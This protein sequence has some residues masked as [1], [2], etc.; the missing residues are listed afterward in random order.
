M[1]LI[2]AAFY[3]RP[4]LVRLG[5][6]KSNEYR[7]LLGGRLFEPDE[8]NPMIALRGASRYIDPRFR[9][10]SE[11]ECEALRFVR[12]Q[13]G[14][15]NLQLMIPFC[16]SPEEGQEVVRLLDGFG[17]SPE[18]GVPLFLMVELPSNVLDAQRFIEAMNLS[19]GS[20]GSNDLVQTV[21]AVSRDDLEHYAH[22]VDARSPAVK[23]MIR[24]AVD[25]FNRNGLEIGICG[26]APSD[27]PED[28]PA[29]LVSCGITSISVTPDTLIR[30][31]MAVAQAEAGR[32][33]PPPGRPA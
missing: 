23:S 6:L 10:A 21:Y 27:H 11:M 14:L 29:F 7:D 3:P 25:E 9:P 22:P 24:M 8:E 26:Q 13:I 1:A 33:D 20:I 28:V 12:Q 18:A 16:R 2:C 31:R 4:V 15:D 32:G 5:D 30:A 17:L 19:G